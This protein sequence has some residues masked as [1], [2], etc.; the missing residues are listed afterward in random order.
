MATPTTPVMVMDR[1]P[2]E[3]VTRYKSNLHC[4][5]LYLKL[6]ARKGDKGKRIDVFGTQVGGKDINDNN[7][8]VSEAA[9]KRFIPAVW[10]AY[11]KGG[12][13]TVEEEFRKQQIP[14]Q[15]PVA[16]KKRPAS[17][18]DTTTLLTEERGTRSLDSNYTKAN[19]RKLSSAEK[20]GQKRRGKEGIK[21]T[22]QIYLAEL[23][24][25]RLGF[26]KVITDLSLKKAR[27]GRM[28]NRNKVRL[29][30]SR[31]RP[32]HEVLSRKEEY[33][34]KVRAQVLQARISLYAE[35]YTRLKGSLMT[36]NAWRYI[37]SSIAGTSIPRDDV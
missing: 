37:I 32:D 12:D 29:K 33:W 25:D 27:D 15:T 9:A 1:V 17:S 20:K 24:E 2:Q 8:W 21:I 26:L 16:L 4:W 10:A 30:D 36:D 3:P 23:W 34:F 14:Y 6:Y 31:V 35:L 22:K 13:A 11:Q 7:H 28:H 5:Y 19:W 18:Q